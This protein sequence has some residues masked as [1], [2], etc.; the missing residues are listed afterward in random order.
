MKRIHFSLALPKWH[1]WL[2]HLAVALLTLTGLAWLFLDKFAVVEGE[3]GPEKHPALPWL[4]LAHGALAYAFLIVAAM[5]V[6]VHMRLGW[7]AARNR[8]SGLSLAAIGLFLAITG[9]ILYYSSAETLRDLASL[10][11]WVVGLALPAMLV[12]HFV[13]GKASRSKPK[14]R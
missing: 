4:L 3:F 2:I 10:S 1:E 13:R 9:L 8:L 5:L 14:Q 6:P 12:I 11:H 7:N